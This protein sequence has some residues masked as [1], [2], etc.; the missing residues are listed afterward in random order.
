MADMTDKPLTL[1]LHRWFTANFTDGCG[2]THTMGYGYCQLL[3]SHLAARV[4]VPSDGHGQCASAPW[5]CP[6]PPAHYVAAPSDGLRERIERLSDA[7]EGRG[8]WLTGWQAAIEA[9]LDVV[10]AARV[11][12][13]S[14]GQPVAPR[15]QRAIDEARAARVAAP[16]NGLR[17]A[18]QYDAIPTLLV[19]AEDNA[20]V[21]AVIAKLRATLDATRPFDP[22]GLLWHDIVKFVRW[23]ANVRNDTREAIAVARNLLARMDAATPTDDPPLTGN[24]DVY[25]LG[26]YRLP[27]AR[28][29]DDSDS[30]DGCGHAGC[31]SNEDDPREAN[32]SPDTKD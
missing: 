21:R 1:D 8:E 11:A 12:A 9:T 23:S 26:D 15:V 5:T 10:D 20:G 13:P 7:N 3:G 19:F 25:G 18:I 28:I 4:A 31:T 27:D 2:G 14:D 17:D 16:S 29:A 6:D 32:Y 22:S 30:Q 24:N